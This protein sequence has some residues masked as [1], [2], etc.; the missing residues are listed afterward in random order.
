MG[1]FRLPLQLGHQGV[2]CPLLQT[3]QCTYTLNPEVMVV[4]FSSS[5][6]KSLN[7][8][9]KLVALNSS[10]GLVMWSSHSCPL[11]S[12]QTYSPDHHTPFPPDL[13]LLSHHIAAACG[14]PKFNAE[15]GILNYYHSDSSLG[16]HVDE[17]ELDHSHPLLS[18][19]S[20]AKHHW[21]RRLYAA[22]WCYRSNCNLDKVLHLTEVFLSCDSFGQSAIFLLGGL[23]R[24]APPTAMYM[25]SGD[26]MVMAGQSR[27][28][29]HAVPRILVAAQGQTTVEVEGSSPASAL[30]ADSVVEPLAEDDWVVCCRYIQSSRVNMTV[31]QVLAPGQNFPEAP[32]SS[33][34]IDGGQEEE[35]HD[36]AVGG[37]KRKRS[38]DETDMNFYHHDDLPE[39]LK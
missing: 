13:H 26:V 23:C 9:Q 31:R 4:A 18:L 25:H 8:L 11:I 3:T 5:P 15:A 12:L 16:I 17:S 32:L 6:H 39:W 14:F 30:H 28:R 38:S 27:L 10:H 21:Q 1:H 7:M 19:R 29:Y 36:R 20:D 33:P 2:H 34:K 37:E 35:N 24:Q 22:Y